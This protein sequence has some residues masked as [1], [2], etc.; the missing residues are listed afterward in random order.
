MNVLFHLATGLGVTAAITN[1]K[2]IERTDKISETL[3]TSISAFFL[4]FIAHA[5][6]DYIPH[7]YP[8]NTKFDFL[9]GGV[10][11]CLLVYLANKKYRLIVL[12]S[13][14][15]SVSPDLIDLLPSILNN[16]LRLNIP[17]FDKIFP[18]HWKEYSGSLYNA[19]NNSISNLNIFFTLFFTCT[20]CWY[21]RDD[22]KCIFN[23][24]RR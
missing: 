4:S 22:L 10:L 21:R 9:C 13:L 19:E 11:F 23:K 12:M 16:Q 1:T 18:W 24:K 8:L 15:G 7:G 5:I 20:I 6:L 14:L 2:H 17:I 3:L